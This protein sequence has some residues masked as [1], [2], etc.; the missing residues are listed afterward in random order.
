MVTCFLLHALPVLCLHLLLHLVLALRLHPCLMLSLHMHMPHPCTVHGIQLFL[1]HL[2]SER[3]IPSKN[4]H[5]K[6]HFFQKKAFFQFF[7]IQKSCFK[8]SKFFPRKLQKFNFPVAR[9]GRGSVLGRSGW[10][11]SGAGTNILRF[12][13]SCRRR[14]FT[15]CPE[16]P[17]VCFAPFWENKTP[18]PPTQVHE[19]PRKDQKRGKNRERKSEA[20]NFGRCGTGRSGRGVQGRRGSRPK[21]RG[22]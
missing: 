5:S 14:C 7:K 15:R 13:F 16:S 21:K 19:N 1:V 20:R 10:E 9:A 2:A 6:I 3:T 12:F 11:R 22:L 4:N 8:I 18:K 17:N